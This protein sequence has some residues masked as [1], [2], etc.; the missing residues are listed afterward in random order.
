VEVPGTLDM[1][2]LLDELEKHGFY[3]AVAE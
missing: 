3:F 2:K 1:S